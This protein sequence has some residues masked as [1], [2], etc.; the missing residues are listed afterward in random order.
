MPVI[1][2]SSTLPSSG[3][4]HLLVFSMYLIIGLASIKHSEIK[5][6]C[7]PNPCQNGG[8]C[9]PTPHGFKCLCLQGYKGEM[10]QGKRK[11]STNHPQF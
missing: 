7:F 3:F 10:C 4:S 11:S 8:S 1:L 5:E 2:S 9:F 6:D